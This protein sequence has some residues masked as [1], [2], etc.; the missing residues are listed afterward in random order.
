[1]NRILG[2][3]LK[4]RDSG[5]LGV[6]GIPC[7][8]LGLCQGSTGAA[9]TDGHGGHKSDPSVAV[10]TPA[11]VNVTPVVTVLTPPLVRFDPSEHYR[12]SGSDMLEKKQML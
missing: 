9:V 5:T 11:A 8:L 3:P 2:K 6:A 7:L 12:R 1:M 10:L 4:T